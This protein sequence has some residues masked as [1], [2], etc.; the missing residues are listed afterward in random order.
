MD[1]TAEIVTNRKGERTGL[2]VTVGKKKHKSEVTESSV[3][4]SV[5][6]KSVTVLGFPED[7]GATEHIDKLMH[8]IK[9]QPGR[10]LAS[11]EHLFALEVN[12]SHIELR[13]SAEP[14]NEAR[15]QYDQQEAIARAFRANLNQNK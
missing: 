3:L 10:H 2:T 11:P 8:S 6:G 5:D 9:K 1:V 4:V 15:K 12:G 14:A 13:R 7:G